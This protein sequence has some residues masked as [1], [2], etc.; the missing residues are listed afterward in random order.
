[1][2]HNIISSPAPHF[3]TFS[4]AC[5]QASAYVLVYLRANNVYVLCN[6]LAGNK[7]YALSFVGVGFFF[8]LSLQ[9]F[10]LTRHFLL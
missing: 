2:F 1:M 6:G 3:S 8:S 4:C 9:W 10:P 5:I 7:V